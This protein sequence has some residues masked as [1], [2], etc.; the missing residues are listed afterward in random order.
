[1]ISRDEDHMLLE[2]LELRRL[3]LEDAKKLFIA[4]DTDATVGQAFIPPG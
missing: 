3:W 1:M 4:A 2:E